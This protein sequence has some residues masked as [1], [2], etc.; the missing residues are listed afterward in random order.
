MTAC[1]PLDSLSRLASY[2]QSCQVTE[3]SDAELADEFFYLC[4]EV[5]S[6][7]LRLAN[8]EYKRNNDANTDSLKQSIRWGG[9]LI[10][11]IA[12][13]A[14]FADFWVGFTVS[15]AGLALTFYAL[16]DDMAEEQNRKTSA[17]IVFLAKERIK[18]LRTEI[19][20]RSR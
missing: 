13:P 4:E 15:I 7:T 1:P 19:A 11:G 2:F 8:L 10:A 17:E 3:M 20:G 18:T 16:A 12:L 5:D 6:L 9:V 14:C